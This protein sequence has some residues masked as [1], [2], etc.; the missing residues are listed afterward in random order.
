MLFMYCVL[1][2]R[3]KEYGVPFCVSH[4]ALAER[5]VVSRMRTE[6]TCEWAM[7][8]ADFVLCEMGEYDPKTGEALCTAPKLGLSLAA[9]LGRLEQ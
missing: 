1:D 8:P 9:I 6:P 3:I 4:G 5:A 2:E 7:F